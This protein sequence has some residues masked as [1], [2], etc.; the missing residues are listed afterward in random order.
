MSE[1]EVYPGK[2]LSD[3]F[4]DVCETSVQKRQQLNEFIIQLQGLIKTSTDAMMVVPMIKDY[5]DIGVRNED[6][7]IKVASI[8]QKLASGK[9]MASDGSGEYL[10]SES[11]KAQLLQETTSIMEK[12]IDVKKELK[13]LSVAKEK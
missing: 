10:L 13:K 9:A 6:L 4:R 8:V 3:L 11:E 12:E 5:M 2:N 7:V 1:I